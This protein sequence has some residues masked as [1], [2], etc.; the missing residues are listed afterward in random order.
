MLRVRPS[1]FPLPL[2]HDILPEVCTF[3]F[4]VVA[5]CLFSPPYQ[6]RGTLVFRHMEL[7]LPSGCKNNRHT[8]YCKF[9][10]AQHKTRM[11]IECCAQSFR[12]ALCE[13]MCT[14]R[15][16]LNLHIQKWL[17]LSIV[18]HFSRGIWSLVKLQRIFMISAN[19]LQ[20]WIN[21]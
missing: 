8:L 21:L 18:G 3:C 9:K 16:S 7:M 5:F 15:V 4:C 20:H 1:G 6:F 11:Y 17:L 2:C 13:T 14:D 10:Q 12:C 19:N